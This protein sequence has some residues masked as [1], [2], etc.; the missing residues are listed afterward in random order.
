MTQSLAMAVGG[1]SGAAARYAVGRLI[2][3][4]AFP[5]AILLINLLGALLLGA[6]MAAALER[7][8]L[9]LTLRLALGTGFCGGF[10]T[11]STW[12]VDSLHLLAGGQVGPALVNMLLSACLGLAAAALGAIAARALLRARA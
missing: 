11:F 12:M 3:E 9:S 6:I 10:T 7:G 8:A 4:T 1:G 5:L 2:G